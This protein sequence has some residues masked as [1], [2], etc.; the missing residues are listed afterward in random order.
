VRILAGS[1]ALL[2][3][4][5]LTSVLR[6][7]L[8]LIWT[9][10]AA[11][12]IIGWKA[13]IGGFVLAVVLASSLC[14]G[15][16]PNSVHLYFIF[17]LVLLLAVAEGCSAWLD[18]RRGTGGLVTAWPVTL[19]KLLLSALYLYTALSGHAVFRGWPEILIAIQIFVAAALWSPLLRRAAFVL[20]LA[21]HAALAGMVPAPVDLMLFGLAALSLYFLFLPSEPRSRIVVWDDRCSFCRAWIRWF[22]R[23][24]WFGVHRFVGS[25]SAEAYEDT[26]LTREQAARAVQLV[27]AG[28]IESGFD[29]VVG[30][31]EVVPLGC[32][33]APL[34]RL[35]PAPQIGRRAYTWVANNRDR[36]SAV[37]RL[38]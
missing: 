35:P 7:D 16:L 22:E 8:L 19:M 21:F 32:F 9:A 6:A 18:G 5:Q 14:A 4:L 27:S 17:C 29:A 1:A 25:S 28:R 26:G 36:L 31:L 2:K 24:D 11:L 37:L 13:Q 12:L 38:H 3:G 15:T 30:L 10:A 23:L 33:W 34:L 20:G